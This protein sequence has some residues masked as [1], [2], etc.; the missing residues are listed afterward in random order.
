MKKIGISFFVLFAI[1]FVYVFYKLNTVPKVVYVKSA[2]LIYSYE[3]MKE[4]Q[5]KQ[6]AKTTE[7][8]SG[9]DSLQ[10]DFQKAIN[11]YNSEFQKLTKDEKLEREKLLSIQ[12]NNIKKYSQSVDQKIKELDE[13]LTQ[14]V[15]AQIN[16]FVEDYAKKK[17]YDLVL[18]TTTSGNILFA[19]DYMDITQD[20]LTELNTNYKVNLK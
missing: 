9:L 18:G 5:Q 2:D 10:L 3:G 15:L 6:T 13:Q 8:K 17:G 4:A 19:K 7:L 12:E 16:S 14:G 20:V 11:Q 1:A